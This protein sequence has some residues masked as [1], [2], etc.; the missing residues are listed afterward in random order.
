MVS[1]FI[2]TVGPCVVPLLTVNEADTLMRVRDGETIVLAGFV[3]TA[4]R[5]KPATGMARFFAAESHTTVTSE[6]VILL[7]PT[8]LRSA[9]ASPN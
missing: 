4:E 2:S 5:S 8:I 6:L 1:P 3:S 7:T 9:G